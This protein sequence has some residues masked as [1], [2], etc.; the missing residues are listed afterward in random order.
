MSVPGEPDLP[1]EP[2]T[3]DVPLATGQ[4]VAR[5][6]RSTGGDSLDGGG[7]GLVRSSAVVAVGTGLS[8]LTG[9]LRTV[10]LAYAV[11]TTFLGDGYNLANT[12]PNMVYDLLLGGILSA[13]LIPVFVDNVRQRDDE[14]SDAVLTVTTVALI[15]VTLVAMAASP[16]I[17]AV[18][19]AG[20]PPDQ[21]RQ[22]ASVAVPL[23]LMFLPQVLF[24]GLTA[25]GTA[26]LNARRRFAV[27]AIAPVLNNLVVIA[28]LA[29][30]ARV[31][32][33]HP[34]IEQVNHDTGLLLLLGLG[35]TAGI[36][37]M[38]VVLW[39][40]IT[41]SGPRPHWRFDHRNPAVRTVARLSGWTFGAVAANQ[42][43]LFV[44]LRL[45]NGPNGEVSAYTYA[46]IFF[47]LP[48]GLLAVSIMTTFMPELASLFGRGDER[49][50]R[51]RFGQGL[52]LIALVTVPA[53]LGYIFLAK[54]IIS[55]LLGYG[56]FTQ[57]SA[58]QTTDALVWLA[59]G[60]PG[61]A[62]F[63]YAMRGFYAR[64]DTKTPFLLYL[65]ENGINIVLAVSL[66]GRFG[67][68][69]VIASYSIAY[70]VSAV[71]ALVVL[72]RRTGGL[73][74]RAS[75]NSLW[76]IAV[77]AVIMAL[78]VWPISRAVGGVSGIG[79]IVRVGVGTA[80]GV[81]AYVGALIVARSPDLAWVVA[82][83]RRRRATSAAEEM[84]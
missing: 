81:A 41:R 20:L 21:A 4:G 46:F 70:A 75:A 3:V 43:A 5:G 64:K 58:Q 32:G 53:A 40:A 45:L 48:Y 11:G 6:E 56:A 73:D 42:A 79:G 37:A 51:Q 13:T 8:R 10:A 68:K 34:T 67:L 18:Y 27:P 30:F 36:V 26:L 19:T 61:F 57:A 49:G 28:M 47:Q 33:S 22:E 69:G 82:R 62:T 2:G 65:V 29:A 52:R 55:V 24:Y 31:A 15:V 38:T 72:R 77:A 44:T 14:A 35:T 66:V 83:L 59:V 25:L 80:V 84:P 63:L 76:R 1:D 54:P 17:V 16:L 78:V 71:A 74:G 60:L 9:L 7:E 39:P 12:T 23:M 50:Y